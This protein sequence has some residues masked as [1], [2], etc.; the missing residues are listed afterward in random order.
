MLTILV[1]LDPLLWRRQLQMEGED[2]LV[3][4]KYKKIMFR[5]HTVILRKKNVETFFFNTIVFLI[6]IFARITLDVDSIDAFISPSSDV[7]N[8]RA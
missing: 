4:P 7:Y 1:I 6:K 3:E 8:K 2:C 5:N